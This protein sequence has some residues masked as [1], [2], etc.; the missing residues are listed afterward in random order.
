MRNWPKV[1]KALLAQ[2]FSGEWLEDGYE[3]R[4]TWDEANRSST[5][6]AEY[7]CAIFKAIS[8]YTQLDWRLYDSQQ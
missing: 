4:V 7:G 5:L 8:E 3:L 1:R 2:Y 6:F